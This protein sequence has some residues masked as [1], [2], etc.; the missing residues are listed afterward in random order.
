MSD[1]AKTPI[2]LI[3]AT[4]YIGGTVL[5]RL[6]SHPS[7][8][9]F[10]ITV[11]VRSEEKAKK[12]EQFGVKPVVGSYKD[13]KLVEELA[14][15]AHVVFSLADAD[16]LPAVQAILR[17]LRK[18]HATIGDLP[19]LI[20]TSGTGVLSTVANGN[21][22][23]ELIYDDLDA[24]QIETIPKDALHR[25]V[26]LPIVEADKE[27]YVRTYIV[28]PSTI[29]SLA[30]NP[31]VEAGIQNPR[32]IQ[33][34]QLI[35]YSIDRGQAGVVGK[36]VS[37]WPDVDI[38][39]LGDL[40]ITLFDAIVNDPEKVGH[41]REGFYFGENGEHPWYDI[42]KEIARVLHEKGLSKTDEPTS[43]TD[44]ELIKY[45][46]SLDAGNYSGS[47]SRCRA[48]RSRSIGW[49]PKK[50]SKDMIASIKPE[51]EYY[52]KIRGQ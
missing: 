2:F 19:I 17:G 11:I 1:T 13:T 29:Y 16:D 42:S 8:N 14:E 34:P 38:D 5:W 35:Q 45:W 43:F 28:V 15:K 9:T 10:D 3:G 22:T 24:D 33:I 12:L 48:N 32:S 46:G 25:D 26:D 51:I 39:D 47:N 4:G 41:G 50:T 36:G 27:G 49:K 23:R 21:F 40:Y 20:H 7:A 6:L 30:S 18:R 44:E 31:L 37:L 52:L